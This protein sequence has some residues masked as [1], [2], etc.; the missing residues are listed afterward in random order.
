MQVSKPPGAAREPP[1]QDLRAI[2]ALSR[3]RRFD[4][5]ETM[6]AALA[7]L[8]PGDVD[9]LAMQAKIAQSRG[10]VIAADGFVAR[11]FEAAP[12]R[13]DVRLMRVASH[14]Y[15][16]RVAEARQL[17]L[18]TKNVEPTELVLR[19]SRLLAELNAHAQSYA[20]IAKAAS[21]R[22]DDLAL[23]AALAGAATALGRMDEAE[24]I[25]DRLCAAGVGGGEVAYNRSTLR[26]QTPER[27]HI[28]ALEAAAALASED[29]PLCY[30]LGKENEDLGRD[31]VAFD[32][33]A[34]GAG[35]RRK[36]LSYDVATDQ[37]VMQTLT[38]TFD[39]NWFARTSAGRST[40]TP[41][42]VLGLPRSG[43]TLVDRILSSHPE[44]ASLGEVNDFA[45]AVTRAGRVRAKFDLIASS[46]DGDMHE[47]GEGYWRALKGY[48]ENTPFL[49][50]K[51]PLNF[52]YV[53][54]IAKA[55]P[56]AR[57]IHLTR[58]P[59]AAG[60]AMF[61][62]YFRMGYPFSYDLV[63]V[64]RYQGAYTRLM[65]HWRGLLGERV[66][67]VA[68]EDVVGDIEGQTRR[69]LAHCGLVWDP[70]CIAFHENKSPT[71]TASAAQ[72][73]RPLYRNSLEQWRRLETQ[74][75]PLAKTLKEEGVL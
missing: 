57:I 61:K 46:A 12:E 72:V 25:A 17:A 7:R 6:A 54:L 3:A 59:M 5:A 66:L 69:M 28:A 27:N 50:D 73:R 29:A 70:A 32:W 56:N 2:E 24:A 41:I 60:Y 42:F 75:A 36:R 30:A 1:R 26:R 44:V 48:G 13:I 49:L 21:A 34:R 33:F 62:T 37:R 19:L 22:P 35:A 38:E 9:V 74:L 31:D 4:E 18:A 43:T 47:L 16:G 10:D 63:D 67:D 52:L 51:T 11:A 39:A 14:L 55:L 53:G 20:V 65:H 71:A 64:G 58:H 23:Q 68:Y 45:Y 40:G 15:C 8:H